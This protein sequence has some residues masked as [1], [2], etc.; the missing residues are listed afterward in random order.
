MGDVVH[1]YENVDHDRNAI[2]NLQ[3]G[4][5]NGTGGGMEARV[6]K[7]ESDV[8][9]IKRDVAEIKTDVREIKRDARNDFRLL[10]SSLI[11]ATIGLASLVAKGFGWI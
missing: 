5:G 6:A 9:Y 11:I 8:D 10:F 4:G 2:K 7:L 1:I 3:S